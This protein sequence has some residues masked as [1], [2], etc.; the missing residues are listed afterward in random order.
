[1]YKKVNFIIKSSTSKDP[2]TFNDMEVIMQ[3]KI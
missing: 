2:N 3:H 1:M